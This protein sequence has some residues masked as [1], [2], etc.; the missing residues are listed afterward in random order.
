MIGLFTP[1]DNLHA[2]DEGF[3]L[4]MMERAICAFEQ[5]LLEIAES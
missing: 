4:G 3:D 1:E 5:I 2:P